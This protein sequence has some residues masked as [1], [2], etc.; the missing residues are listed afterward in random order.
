MRLKIG[1]LFDELTG[2]RSD[3][4]EGVPDEGVEDQRIEDFSVD[5]HR[6]LGHSSVGVDLLQ[7]AVDVDHSSVQFG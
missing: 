3:S 5:G 1:F 6:S 4:A 2:L 7:D